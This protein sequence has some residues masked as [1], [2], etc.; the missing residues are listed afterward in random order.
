MRIR[1]LAAAV[2]GLSLL[3]PASALAAPETTASGTDHTT[4]IMFGLII[5]LMLLLVAIGI[6][7]QRKS[8]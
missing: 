2:A 4:E 7:E 6:I 3:A 1:T 5:V 8:H